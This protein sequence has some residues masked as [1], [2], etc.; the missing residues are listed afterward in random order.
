Y[1]G[2]FNSGIHRSTDS[3]GV[4]MRGNGMVD[5]VDATTSDPVNADINSGRI[6]STNSLRSGD[7]VDHIFV[8]SD[9]DVL[10]WEQLVRISGGHYVTPKV[11]D[12]KALKT[13]VSLEAP[14]GKVGTATLT[15]AIPSDG[16]AL[17]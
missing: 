4:M 16:L 10:N 7:Y 17:R 11:S 2:D 14:V 12:H 3:P 13:V 9:I 6:S 8:S 1:A 5:S 15:T